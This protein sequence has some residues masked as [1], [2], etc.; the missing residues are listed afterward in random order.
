VTFTGAGPHKWTATFAD[1]TAY[2]S[3]ER[4]LQKER[5]IQAGAHLAA[6]FEEIWPE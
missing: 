6:I 4:A 3:D 5:I 2:L 1:R